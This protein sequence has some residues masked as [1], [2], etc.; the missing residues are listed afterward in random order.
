MLYRTKQAAGRRTAVAATELAILLPFL[1]F[2]WV[3]TIDW[4][5]IF[6]YAVTIQ[7]ACRDGAYYA[8]DYP[9][10]YKYSSVT[11]AV[12]SQNTNL[13]PN[14]ITLNGYAAT[15]TD[16]TTATFSS[17]DLS[18]NG[19]KA[20]AGSTFVKIEVIYVFSTIT[21]FPGVPSSTT[22]TKSEIMRVAPITPG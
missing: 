14:N 10:I 11:D 19:G 20:P 2:M 5:R 7:Y 3:I 4:A 12:T 21:N 8:T 1:M 18:V 22:I 13:D 15:G 9:G 6:Y 17:Y 16:P